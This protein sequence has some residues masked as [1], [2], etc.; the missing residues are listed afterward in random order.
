MRSR[1]GGRKVGQD[2]FRGEYKYLGGVRMK[3]KSGWKGLQDEDVNKG[4][5]I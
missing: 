3:M 2:F 5:R 4:G 1:G